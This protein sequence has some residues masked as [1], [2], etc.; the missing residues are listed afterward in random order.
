[1]NASRRDLDDLLCKW[2]GVLVFVALLVLVL[3]SGH[4]LRA[5]GHSAAPDQPPPFLK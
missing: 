2:K 3:L 4:A 1:M 5:C